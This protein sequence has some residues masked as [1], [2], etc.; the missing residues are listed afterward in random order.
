MQSGSAN[1]RNKSNGKQGEDVLNGNQRNDTVY[2]GKDSN[3]VHGGKDDDLS[4][5]FVIK[6]AYPRYVRSDLI[7][8]PA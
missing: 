5:W 3:V 6:L 4:H 2:G 7:P 1:R 8:N